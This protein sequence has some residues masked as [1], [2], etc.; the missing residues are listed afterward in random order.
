VFNNTIS[1]YIYNQKVVG[2]NGQDSVIVPGNQTFQY[3]A[4]KAQLYGGELSIDIHPHPLDWLHFENS[5]SVVYGINKGVDGKPV[6]DSAH[7]LPFIPPFHGISELRANFKKPYKRFKNTFIKVQ[8]AYYAAQNNVYLAYN[9][10]TSTPGYTL[11][12][13]GLGADVTNHKGNILFNIAVFGNN[14]F[15][16]A[17]QDHL[18]RLKYFGT[19]GIYNMG[20]NIGVKL[21]VP[22]SWDISK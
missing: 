21:S 11:F 10:E 7:Y 16:V 22:L 2:K 12:N 19:P 3:E 17:Y 8:V 18:S 14:L 9:T 15:D 6:G 4:A 20:R 5:L 13:A 1:N